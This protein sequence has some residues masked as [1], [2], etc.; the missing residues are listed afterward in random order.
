MNNTYILLRLREEAKVSLKV[1]GTL[2]CIQ[3]PKWSLERNE[4][5]MALHVER[6]MFQNMP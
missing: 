5:C 2:K 1:H 6:M 4:N 3:I